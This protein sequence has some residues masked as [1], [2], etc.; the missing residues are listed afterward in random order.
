M[1]ASP[2]N[3]RVFTSS[4]SSSARCTSSQASMLGARL[5]RSLRR[6]SRP[7]R[8]LRKRAT[9]ETIS[10]WSREKSDRGRSNR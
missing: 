9:C 2:L 8:S 7:N 6:I 5:R 1:S 3:H 10:S 4:V